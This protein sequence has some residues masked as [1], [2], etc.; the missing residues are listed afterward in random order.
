MKCTGLVVI[1]Y[2]LMAPA[3]LLNLVHD[4]KA[5]IYAKAT[6]CCS[7]CVPA[8]LKS[9][10]KPTAL[11]A[12]LFLNG[13]VRFNTCRYLC[14]QCYFAASFLIAITLSPEMYFSTNNY[15]KAG[16]RRGEPSDPRL[17]RNLGLP[18]HVLPI[19]MKHFNPQIHRG[20]PAHGTLRQALGLTERLP[21]MPN[22]PTRR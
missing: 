4:A 9:G 8:I 18:Q 7:S 5:V 11:R 6:L 13:K 17:G 16:T 19:I 1:A 14:N 21:R 10:T 3:S 15:L 2:A 22:R 20:K 12:T